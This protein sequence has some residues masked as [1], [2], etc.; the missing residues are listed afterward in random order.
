[1]EKL[2]RLA[3]DEPLDFEFFCERRGLLRYS[4]P[5]TLEALVTLLK[6]S[7]DPTLLAGG[8][9]VGLWVTKQ[10]RQLR[11]IVDLTK[12]TELQVIREEADQ[13]VIGAG[14]T[15]SNARP[16]LAAHFPDFDPL[17]ARIASEP[18]RNS[19][20]IGGNVAN[21]SP[22]GDTPPAL[23]ALGAR[24]VLAS[25]SGERTVQVEDFFVAY[26]KQDRAPDEVLVRIE[27]PKLSAQSAFRVFKISKRFDQDISALCGGFHAELRS[28][29]LHN[30]R[31][32]FGGMAGVPLRAMSVERA[33][34][35]RPLD[36]ETLDQAVALVPLDYQPLSDHRA[37]A[38]Y[39]LL[40]AQNLLR[41]FAASLDGKTV[42][43]LDREFAR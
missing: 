13:I 39:R 15:Y 42:V 19:G 29:I 2:L 32:C 31:I 28:G 10:H 43:T 18:V 34:E 12:V 5:R 20:T 38:E 11:H 35:G 24:A 21:G 16:V 1:M 33:L 41:K 37:S 9:D 26:G 36:P 7:S 23:I 40:A 3:M 6:T 22:I 17:I 27:I 14:V 4:A 25:S 8:T 30:V